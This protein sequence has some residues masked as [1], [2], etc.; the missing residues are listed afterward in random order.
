MT[1]EAEFLSGDVMERHWRYEANDLATVVVQR[2]KGVRRKSTKRVPATVRC[3][4][5]RGC[6]TAKG[7]VTHKGCITQVGCITLKAQC[8][9]GKKTC[10]P[11]CEPPLRRKPGR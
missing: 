5:D 3:V 2:R 7:C 10:R 9:T 4:T 1:H 11:P 6:I 8:I